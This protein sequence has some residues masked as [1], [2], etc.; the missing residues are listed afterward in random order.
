M[1]QVNLLLTSVPVKPIALR[2]ADVRPSVDDNAVVQD[3]SLD[4]S[5]K[6]SENDL[7]LMQSNGVTSQS[8]RPKFSL[9]DPPKKNVLPDLP[10]SVEQQ[11][12]PD[13]LDSELDDFGELSDL[14]AISK[15]SMMA[16][17][18]TS[19]PVFSTNLVDFTESSSD[20]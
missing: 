13:S 1:F 8:T 18:R 17:R 14:P 2:P 7:Q 10:E 3:I 6:D 16:M 5:E 11:S 9:V 12:Q 19:E 4:L 15:R 20:S